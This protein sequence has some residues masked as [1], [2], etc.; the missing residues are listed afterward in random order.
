MNC[1]LCK[2]NYYNINGTDNCYS[3]DLINNGFYF[4]NNTFYPC[5]DNCLTCSDS[6]S[7]LNS[8]ITTNNC[9]SCDKT[10]KDLYLVDQLNKGEPK[11]YANNSYFLKLNNQ[12]IEKFYKCYQS[13]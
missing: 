13:C 8:G 5:S 1:I 12:G 7:I 11:S 2:D 6:P 9:L 3:M 4:T 10:N